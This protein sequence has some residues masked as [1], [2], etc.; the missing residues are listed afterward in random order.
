MFIL[1]LDTATQGKVKEPQEQAR[2]SETHSFLK[3]GV[4]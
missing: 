2:E 1:M 3:F 4:L